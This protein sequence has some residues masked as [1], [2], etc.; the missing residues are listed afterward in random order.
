MLESDG[1]LTELTW[2]T[3]FTYLLIAFFLGAF[4]MGGTILPNNKDTDNSALVFFFFGAMLISILV[5]FIVF[6]FTEGHAMALLI[7]FCIN[8][9]AMITTLFFR[10]HRIRILS[11]LPAFVFLTMCIVGISRCLADFHSTTIAESI[12]ILIW[13]LMSGFIAFVFMI[14]PFDTTPLE[15]F[16]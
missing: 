5:G 15:K 10:L 13:S 1:T 7:S 12:S 2:S 4:A 3:P 9:V 11:F 8:C 16:K 6:F 14:L